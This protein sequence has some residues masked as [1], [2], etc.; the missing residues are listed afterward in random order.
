VGKTP[1]ACNVVSLHLKSG[2]SVTAVQ[3]GKSI[4]NTMGLTPLEGLMMGTRHAEQT[5]FLIQQGH[6]FIDLHPFLTHQQRN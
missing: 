2:C 6:H 5:R 4:D 3:E 1:A